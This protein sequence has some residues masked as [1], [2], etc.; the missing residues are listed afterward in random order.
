M[1]M[2]KAELKLAIDESLLDEAEA[3]GAE[4]SVLIERTLKA[5]H[6]PDVAEARARRWAEENADA[7]ASFNQFVE[8]NGAFGEEWRRW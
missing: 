2:G 6:S 3:S 4:L 8:E 5:R 7:I 1:I